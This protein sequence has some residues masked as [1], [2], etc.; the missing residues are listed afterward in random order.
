VRNDRDFTREIFPDL[1]KI[2][3]FRSF[4]SEQLTT[5]WREIAGS[6]LA[7]GVGWKPGSGLWGGLV[8]AADGLPERLGS[9]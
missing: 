1:L 6:G 3:K 5:I 2:L 9:A 7:G 8:A 4:V